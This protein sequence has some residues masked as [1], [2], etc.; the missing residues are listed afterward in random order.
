MTNSRL[1]ARPQ[2]NRALK[3]AGAKISSWW[4]SPIPPKFFGAGTEKSRIQQ[5]FDPDRNLMDGIKVWPKEAKRLKIGIKIQDSE[6][7][8]ELASGVAFI[9]CIAKEPH[10]NILPSNIFSIELFWK[11]CKLT[12]YWVLTL[13]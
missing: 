4:E 1:R 3:T 7:K 2:F 13:F 12:N 8:P 11:L 10:T 6:R 9:S 5:K